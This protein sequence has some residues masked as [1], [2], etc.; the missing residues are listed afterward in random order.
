MIR[1]ITPII[2]ISG[3]GFF[4]IIFFLFQSKEI[5]AQ[6]GLTRLSREEISITVDSVNSKLQQNY[7]FPDLADKMA[8]KLSANLNEGKYWSI[9]APAEFAGQLT[10]DLQMVSNDKHLRVNYNPQWIRSE[11][12]TVSEKDKVRREDQQV[13]HMKRNNYGFQ[14]IQI[15]EGNIG[16]L[17]LRGFRDP[18]FAGKT[19]VAALNFLSNVD[20]LIVDLRQNGGGSPSMIQL[21][22]SYFFSPEPVHLNNFYFRPTDESTQ[23]WTLPYVPGTRRSDIDLYL[24]T[25]TYTFSAAEEFSYNLRNL[26]RATI[27]GETT[28]GGAHPGGP[29]VATDNFVVWVPK[30]RAINPITKTNWEG[31]GV[32]PH[33]EVSSEDALLIAQIHTIEKLSASSS[34]TSRLQLYNWI[35]S[36]LNATK[37]PIMVEDFVLNGYVGKYGQAQIIITR[38]NEGLYYEREGDKKHLLIPISQNQFVLDGRLSWLKIQFFM[39]DGKVVALNQVYRNGNTISNL[40]DE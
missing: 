27:I 12:E 29:V 25:S 36:G 6:E 19:A 20:A 21:I 7:I 8:Q 22:T 18:K 2:K 39:E 26:E 40:K 33:I 23:T 5:C 38:A 15:L 4:H 37:N 28:G 13:R 14:K 10:A 11:R 35:L 34:D 31:V 3:L 1:L 16:F 17:D 9:G 32:T 30:G 24:L